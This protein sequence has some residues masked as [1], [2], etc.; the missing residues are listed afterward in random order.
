[1]DKGQGYKTVGFREYAIV[2]FN[3]NTDVNQTWHE[4]WYKDDEESIKDFISD[5]AQ[6][7]R[8]TLNEAL[9]VFFRLSKRKSP[10]EL[11]VVRFDIKISEVKVTVDEQTQD[12]CE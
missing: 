7:T 2:K 1:M 12:N 6:A 4:G 3:S 11:K 5:P 10:H 8:M 9:S